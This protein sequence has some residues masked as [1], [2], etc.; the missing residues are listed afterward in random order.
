MMARGVRV[1]RRIPIPITFARP[2]STLSSSRRHGGGCPCCA[3]P[4]GAASW[5]TP[6]TA[7]T[8]KARPIS[9]GPIA[10]KGE[11]IEC[12]ALVAMAVN[13]LQLKRVKVAPPAPGEVRVK[14]VANAI[15]HTDLYTLEGSDPEGLFPCILGHEAGGIVESIGEG[16]TSVAV[17]DHVVP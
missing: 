12:D 1:P 11:A 17:G 15:C 5:C 9:F 2:A 8:R 10:A 14:V 13:D 7:S 16:V 3:P 4:S 6:S